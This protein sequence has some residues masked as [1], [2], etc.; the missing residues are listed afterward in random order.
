MRVEF[1]PSCP[2]PQKICYFSLF[3]FFNFY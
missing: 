1:G 3:L 2:A